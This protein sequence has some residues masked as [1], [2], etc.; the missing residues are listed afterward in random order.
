LDYGIQMKSRSKA[1]Q[2][3]VIQL[4]NGAG[5]VPTEKAVRGGGYSAVVQSN[6]VGFEG[7]QVLADRT[8]ELI[9]SLW[10]QSP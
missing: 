7:G 1:I 8:V 10:P 6:K 5:Y 4:V 2:T 9:N 3:F